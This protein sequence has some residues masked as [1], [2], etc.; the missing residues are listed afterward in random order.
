MDEHLMT[1]SA[2]VIGHHGQARTPRP[3]GVRRVGFLVQTDRAI[4]PPRPR[5]SRHSRTSDAVP[6][7][8]Q[9]LSHYA[10]I[11]PS[12][13][14]V[15]ARFGERLATG[16][17]PDLA[18]DVVG[19]ASCT[20][21]DLNRDAFASADVQCNWSVRGLYPC[22]RPSRVAARSAM[23]YTVALVLPATIVGMTEPSAIRSPL[24]LC[25]LSSGSTTDMAPV[26]IRQVPTGWK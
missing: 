1:R 26:P 20:H 12:F 18:R 16:G 9:L 11:P 10:P 17:V 5:S 24:M 3:A 19:E 21:P 7:H 15:Q 25:T 23:A 22:H 8:Q 4:K 13:G 6:S 2:A 14:F